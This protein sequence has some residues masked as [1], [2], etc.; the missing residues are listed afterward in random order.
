MVKF[1]YSCAKKKWRN[2][3]PPQ[4]RIQDFGYGGPAQFWPQTGPEPKFCSKLPENCQLDPLV[5]QRQNGENRS[6]TFRSTAMTWGQWGRSAVQWAL[7]MMNKGAYQRRSRA[8]E[9]EVL[10]ASKSMCVCV[11]VCNFKFLMLFELTWKRQMSPPTGLWQQQHND[12]DNN[13]I[14]GDSDKRLR[15]P[16]FGGVRLK[17]RLLAPKLGHLVQMICGIKRTVYIS[18]TDL[19]PVRREADVA[20]NSSWEIEKNFSREKLQ[21]GKPTQ[22]SNEVNCGIEDASVSWWKWIHGLGLGWCMCA[23]IPVVLGGFMTAGIIHFIG[24]G[25]GRVFHPQEVKDYVGFQSGLA[26]ARGDLC[27]HSAVFVC[28]SVQCPWI[29]PT[30]E[31]WFLS[32]SCNLSNFCLFEKKMF[33]KKDFTF[34]A[35]LDVSCFSGHLSTF[36][37]LVKMLSPQ[38]QCLCWKSTRLVDLL[39]AG[40][41]PSC[42]SLLVQHPAVGPCW[43]NTQL[44]MKQGVTQYHQAFEFFT[45]LWFWNKVKGHPPSASTTGLLLHFTD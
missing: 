38:K 32:G 34:L 26:T 11:C 3:Q 10:W 18:G 8:P 41:T 2:K 25:G 16:A 42:G 12:H 40:S 33:L 17:N 35:F 44:W 31:T 13:G 15:E 23:H 29:S 36:Q 1:C 27:S 7:K 30:H 22:L 5:H 20:K 45:G 4:G 43:F 39:P 37:I 6:Q 28:L 19:P 9:Q 14:H 21:F 24:F